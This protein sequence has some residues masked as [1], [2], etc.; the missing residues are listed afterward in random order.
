MSNDAYYAEIGNT[1]VGDLVR[2]S[3]TKFGNGQKVGAEGHG[4]KCYNPYHEI[5]NNDM[6]TFWAVFHS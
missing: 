4:M 3:I 2:D 5:N 1:D 6:T